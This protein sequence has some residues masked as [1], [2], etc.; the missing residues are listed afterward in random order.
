MYVALTRAKRELILHPKCI[1][2]IETSAQM[3][4]IAQPLAVSGTIGRP[5]QA[6]SRPPA[7]KTS[8]GRPHGGR[9]NAAP[10]VRRS[11][12]DFSL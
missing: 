11:A 5:A 4:G 7:G 3:V 2:A 10:M 1:E 9:G 12:G 8:N 6:N